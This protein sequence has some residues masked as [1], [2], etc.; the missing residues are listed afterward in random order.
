MSANDAAIDFE[1]EYNNRIRVPAWQTLTTRT[2]ELSAAYRAECAARGTSELAVAYGSDPR[3]RYDVFRAEAERPLGAGPLCVF[4]HGGYW[5]RGDRADASFV[6]RHLNAAG[7]DVVLPSYR[8]CPAVRVADIVEDLRGCLAS[9][10]ARTGRRPVVVGHSAGGHLAA[11]MLATDW[12]ARGADL[13]ADLVRAA[14]P[15]SGA[16]DPTA[17]LSTSLN[18]ALRLTADEATALNIAQWKAPAGADLV[19]VVGGGESGEFLRQTL[20]LVAIWSAAGIA[21][22]AVVVPNANHFTVLQPFEQASSA[23]LRRILQLARAA[24]IGAGPAST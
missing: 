12:P 13:P 20:D 7:V 5:Q 14:M 21:A 18:E 23:M 1:A 6:A 2:A 11:A 3:H 9:L 19:A 15:I 4:I 22:E 17:L 10:W 8:L 24:T 16:F